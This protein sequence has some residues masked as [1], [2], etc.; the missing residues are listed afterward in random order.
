MSEQVLAQLNYIK[1]SR[2]A[3]V[4]SMAAKGLQVDGTTP[5][6]QLASYIDQLPHLGE[7]VYDR[8]VY[9]DAPVAF[10]DYDG[11]VLY[12]Y[13][14]E[15]FLALSALPA[16][17]TNHTGLT[18]QEWNWDL[19]DAK[20][21]ITDYEFLDIGVNY[22]TTSG[23]TEIF[24]ELT[25]AALQP[26]LGIGLNGTATID[27]GD[28]SATDTITGTSLT[29]VLN[30]QHTYAQAGNYTITLT[31]SQGSAQLL[32][33]SYGSYLLWANVS[34]SSQYSNNN[35]YRS[36]IKEIH[37]G[38]N[39]TFGSY[40]LNYCRNLSYITIPNTVTSFNTYCFQNCMS[41]IHI[42]FSKSFI[43]TA[44]SYMLGY[45]YNLC[46]VSLSYNVSCPSN[47]NYFSYLF[48]S[49]R[50]LRRVALSPLMIRIGE[51][52]FSDCFALRSIDLPDT[53]TIIGASAFSS[54][55]NLSEITIPRGVST[56]NNSVFS[57]CF[58]LKKI[59]LPNT[60]VSIY[61]GVFG[62]CSCLGTI[63]LPQSLTQLGPTSGNGDFSGCSSLTSI[64]IPDSITAIGMSEFSNCVSLT[65]IHIPANVNIIYSGA[66]QSCNSLVVVDLSDH[67]FV[68]TLST[69]VF[70]STPPGMRI[71][72][73]SSLLA[74]FQS[75]TNWSAYASQMVGV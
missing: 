26:Y 30:T 1:S 68:P 19:Q 56:L 14:K 18:A 20:D 33:N 4:N 41:L 58:N 43:S 65:H 16:L 59:I 55:Y 17:P 31:I 60:L 75:A 13:T 61:N 35:I 52:M 70:S 71:Y 32:G 47:Q 3:I 40:A 62:S 7:T 73:P 50:S 39:I 36:A 49:C 66:F 2:D 51:R 21:Y 15:E 69:G 29:T 22:I 45:C 53:V 42:V 23:A 48:Y 46:T 9:S 5:M 37:F 34:G 38:T 44:I 27:W 10:Y 54:C 57:S 11:T 6:G 8:N 72:V 28:N 74:D 64:N 63:E 25:Q 67:E 12:E 24:I